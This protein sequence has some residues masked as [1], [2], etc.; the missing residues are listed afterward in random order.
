MIQRG[1]KHGAL[2]TAQVTAE[3]SSLDPDA[4]RVRAAYSRRSEER[5]RRLYS[6]FNT[7]FLY[8]AQER[9]RKI[10]ELMKK[11]GHIRLQNANILEVGC[12]KGRLL[13][14]LIRW[15]ACPE[16]LH[17]IDILT[18]H[19]LAARRICPGTVSLYTRS[20]ARLEFPDST[21]DLVIQGTTFSSIL[22]S[23]VRVIAANEMLRV[24]RPDGAIL[25]YD[26][27]YNNPRNP[28]VRGLNEREIRL[29][30][31]NCRAIFKRVTLAP[32]LAR[33][34]APRSRFLF[35]A[36]TSLRFLSTHHLALITREK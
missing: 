2:E 20:A 24:L 36:L 6:S 9:E 35:E 29:L 7:A 14:D 15:G 31:P 32:P 13:L 1:S 30:F 25:W 16:R 18:E 28:D 5:E 26:F 27:S 19:V 22:N 23:E 10:L 4:S 21:F 17:G 11:Y 12:E 8:H 33:I 3:Q 34:I